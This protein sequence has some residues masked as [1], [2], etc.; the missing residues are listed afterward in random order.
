MQENEYWKPIPGFNERYYASNMG[1]VMSIA[2]TW[3]KRCH[4][5]WVDMKSPDVIFDTKSKTKKG[6]YRT[7]LKLENGKMKTYMIHRLIAKT[8]L[9]EI[10]DKM[11]VNHING[12]KTDN[13]IYNLEI[14]TNQQNRDHARDNN[15]IANR[16]NGLGKI[17]QEQVIEIKKLY[18]HGLK[19]REIAKKFNVCQQTISYIIKE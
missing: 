17:N 2:C 9:G 14:V 6:Y 15:L 11:Q 10:P 8:F 13:S 4:G 5:K 18:S 16:K 19:Q 12:I 1:R 3:K 7:N